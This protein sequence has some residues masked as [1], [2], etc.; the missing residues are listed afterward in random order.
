MPH[1][2]PSFPTPNVPPLMLQ[3]K[4][5]MTILNRNTLHAMWRNIFK[6][7]L[8]EMVKFRSFTSKSS[9]VMLWTSSGALGQQLETN[10]RRRTLRRA[11]FPHWLRWNTSFLCRE[12]RFFFADM[13]LQLLYHHSFSVLVDRIDGL[14]PCSRHVSLHSLRKLKKFQIRENEKPSRT[15]KT[16]GAF[17]TSQMTTSGN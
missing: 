7:G 10:A 1:P 13:I 11:P 3:N 15:V 8:C 16:T 17:E 14:S 12:Q 9:S 6:L 4:I 2:Q 5:I